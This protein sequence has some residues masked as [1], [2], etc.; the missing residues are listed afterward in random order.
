MRCAISVAVL[1]MA[2]L[3]CG[4]AVRAEQQLAAASTSTEQAIEAAVTSFQS[5]DRYWEV[6]AG[7][8]TSRGTYG[9][10]ESTSVS[11]IPV[12]A[13]YHSGDWT[14]S[15]DSGLMRVKGALDYVDITNRLNGAVGQ[16]GPG[17]ATAAVQGIADTTLG[18]KYAMFEDLEMGLF[19][20]VG[21]RLRLPTANSK[22][23]LGTGHV[24]GDLQVEMTKAF[25]RW[26]VFSAAEYGIRDGR[27]GDRNP[28]SA[29][30]GIN[31]SL[32]DRL[33]AG[34]FY[35]WRQSSFTGGRAAHEV[36]IYGAYRFNERF[37]VSLYGATG[38]SPQSVDRELG[39]RYA[40]RWN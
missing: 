37:S 15:L 19:V 7:F 10:V 18:V 35:H 32:T 6:S 20:D 1:G 4:T 36:F 38:F 23:G 24:A 12:G 22:K 9:A 3:R 26:S 11:Y 13:A 2:A 34:T 14:V 29:S 17:A 33:S 8:D 30:A 27:D 16:P 40:F 31:R 39:V 28:W 21:G 5:R 25:G